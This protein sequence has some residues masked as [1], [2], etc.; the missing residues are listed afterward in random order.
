MTP[1]FLLF[2]CTLLEVIKQKI[3]RQTKRDIFINSSDVTMN[4]FKLD[5]KGKHLLGTDKS[6]LERGVQST[7]NTQNFQCHIHDTSLTSY[8]L[9]SSINRVQELSPKLVTSTHQ[10][11]MLTVSRSHFSRDSNQ[12]I[13]K[14]YAPIKKLSMNMALYICFLSCMA[15]LAVKSLLH[16]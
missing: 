7:S 15:S 1:N 3:K 14:R 9:L 6:F 2:S 13:T 4:P 5:S 10:V 8:K 12:T 11:K 16:L